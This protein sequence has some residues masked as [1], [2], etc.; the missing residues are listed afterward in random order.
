ME[1]YGSNSYWPNAMYWPR[2]IPGHPTMIVCVVSGHHGVSRVG[3]LVL[4]DPATGRHEADGVVQ[5]IPG[6]GKKVEP[7]IEDNLV[8]DSWPQFAAPYPLAEPETNL[9]AGKYFL[10]CVQAR[11]RVDLGPVPGRRLRQHHADPHGRLHD[12]DP[13]AAAAHAAG[14]PVAGRP[15]AQGRDRLPGRR[16]P[17]RRAAGLSPAARSRPCAS[18]RT[19][20]ATPATATPGRRRYEGGWD[21]KRILGTVPVNED[22]SAIFRVPANTPIFVQPLDAEGKAQQVRCGAGSRPCRARSL[23]CV[24]CHEKQNSGPPSR[25]SAA[26]IGAGPA[27]IAPWYGPA[28]GFSFDREVQPVLDRRCVGCH[29]GQPYRTATSTV[30]TLDL[31]AKRLHDRI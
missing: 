16:L 10:A 2:P 26:A 11:R 3:E 6:Y 15:D 27:A 21:V 31:R 29:N 14:H 13:A 1:Y 28:R 23:S 30:A 20:T 8:G 22:G 5:R 9:G 17:G 19:T 4:L 24:G 25:Y 12:A 7:I 18:A